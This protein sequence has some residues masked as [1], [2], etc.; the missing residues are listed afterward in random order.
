MF[1][2]LKKDA[3]ESGK[4]ERVRMKLFGK[5]KSKE[6]FSIGELLVATLILLMVSS[7]VAGGIPVARDAYN[8]VTIGANSQVLLSTTISALRN[9]LGTA[10]EKIEPNGSTI[11]YINGRTGLKTELYTSGTQGIKIK[12]YNRAGDVVSDRTLVPEAAATEDLYATF[13]S[14]ST[15]AKGVLTIKN[16]EV[17]RSSDAAT[18]A[19]RAELSELKIRVIRAS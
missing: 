12:E 18:D 7:V 11:T 4:P 6:G 13:G 8:K 1:C 15:F 2:L 17:K 3:S 10:T 19:G 5:L 16:L 14:D 9:E